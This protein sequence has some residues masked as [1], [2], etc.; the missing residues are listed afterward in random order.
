[1]TTSGHNGLASLNLGV[2]RPDIA[3]MSPHRRLRLASAVVAI[4]LL[5]VE[6]LAT[7]VAPAPARASLVADTS[8]AFTSSTG[9]RQMG[10][11]SAP[12]SMLGPREPAVRVEIPNP[13]RDPVRVR[14]RLVEIER[15]LPITARPGGGR[16]VGTMPAGSRYYAI[17]TVAWVRELSRDGRHG[18]VDIPYVARRASGWIA[19]RGLTMAWTRVSVEADL[20]EHRITVRRGDD[21]LF[22][23]P[24]ATGAPVSPTPTGRYFVTDRVPFPSGGS[25]GTFAFG[26]SGIQPNLPAGWSGGDQ[27]A[28]HGT[29]DPS[30]IGRSAS[31]GCLRVS[32]RVLARLKR[33]LRLGTPVVVRA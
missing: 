27:L 32:E 28:I 6:A 10:A 17:P 14:H 20:S 7:G 2:P 21:V 12:S 15:A 11:A 22:R 30:S 24:A 23:A 31:A 13:S 26:I 3:D 16:V 4:S 9:A 8:A 33:L 19:L 5:V 25:L 1:V 29:N 18:L